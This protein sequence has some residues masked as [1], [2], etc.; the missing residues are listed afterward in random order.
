VLIT[1]TRHPYQV[2]N[3]P[4]LALPMG[5]TYR[6]RYRA[7]YLEDAA[8][9]KDRENE[10][11]ILVLRD[12]QRGK[13]IP[14]RECRLFRIEHYGDYV[15]FEIEF[16]S[17]VS[18]EGTE[19]VYLDELLSKPEAVLRLQDEREKYSDS[20]E[21]IV[22]GKG[23]ANEPGKDLKKVFF[24]VPAGGVPAVKLYPARHLGDTVEPWSRISDY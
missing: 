4:I 13:F 20:I 16:L 3:V 9:I 7:S 11:G 1:N 5:C 22:K 10:K 2:H 18:Y 12:M 14:L 8:S 23:L 15:F 19:G 21:D 24:T 17:F 6:F